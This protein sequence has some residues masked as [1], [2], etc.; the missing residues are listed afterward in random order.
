MI[1]KL[2]QALADLQ[3]AKPN[4]RSEQDRRYAIL[5]TETEKLIALYTA[6]L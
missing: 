4:D 2:Q 3:T 1:E 5:I 6:W